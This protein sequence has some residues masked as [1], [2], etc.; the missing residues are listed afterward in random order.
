MLAADR[1]GRRGLTPLWTSRD[2]FATVA[3]ENSPFAKS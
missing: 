3:P 1:G 2:N